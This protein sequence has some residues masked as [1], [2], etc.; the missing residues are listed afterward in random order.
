MATDNSTAAGN[1]RGSFFRHLFSIIALLLFLFYVGTL[2]YS[3]YNTR[4]DSF[5][6][7]WIVRTNIVLL[8]VILVSV[9][10]YGAVWHKH[11]VG[12]IPSCLSVQYVKFR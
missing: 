5:S 11:T 9:M 2:A 7:V 1:S 3:L 10:L 12:D 4:S 6:G 8:L